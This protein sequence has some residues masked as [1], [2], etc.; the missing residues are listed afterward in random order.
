MV[1]SGQYAVVGYYVSLLPG[2]A[3]LPLLEVSAHR[4]ELWF[5]GSLE[6]CADGSI[7]GFFVDPYRGAKIRGLL[8]GEK[9]LLEKEYVTGPLVG[10]GLVYYRLSI[11]PRETEFVRLVGG[12]SFRPDED[13]RG[14]VVVRLESH[15]RV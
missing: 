8:K 14:E 10:Q 6:V 9:V 2:C 15:P 13:A 5:G 3:V 12:Y 4:E 11:D 1:S 7:S